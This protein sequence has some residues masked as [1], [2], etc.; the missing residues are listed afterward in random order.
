[1]YDRETSLEY[2]SP[3]V[4]DLGMPVPATEIVTTEAN[5]GALMSI[6]DGSFTPEEQAEVEKLVA[7]IQAA[8]ELLPMTEILK[9]DRAVLRTVIPGIEEDR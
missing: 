4:R 7:G 3:V 8:K 2:W 6:L 1:M 5:G 9:E